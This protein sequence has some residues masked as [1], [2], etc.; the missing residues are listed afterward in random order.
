MHDLPHQLY[1]AADVR[2]LDRCAIE[3]FGISGEALMSR[4]GAAAFAVLRQCWP[5][6]ERIAVLCGTG[7]NGGDGFVLARLAHE[8]G[9]EVRVLRLGDT[10]LVRGDAATAA[11]AMIDA[12][13]STQA[14]GGGDLEGYDVIVD[15]MLGT[16]LERAVEGM[17]HE[18]IEEVNAA[19]SGVLALDI[20]SGLHADTGAIL[21]V[22]VEAAVTIAFI[23]LKQ[24]MFT[25]RGP[26]CCGV[27]RY[28]DLGVPA[29][30]FTRVPPSCLRLSYATVA[31]LLRLRR[32][33]AHKG[34]HGHVLVVGGDDGMAGAARLAGEAAARTGAG[35]V[36][37]ATRPAHAAALAAVRPELM[38]HGV[39]D[40]AALRPLLQRADVV[41]LGPGLG[42]RQWGQQ[43]LAEVLQTRLPLVVDADALNLLA[44]DPLH[45]D[46]W[47]L[48]PHPGEAGRLLGSDAA[49]V[50]ADRFAA[51]DAIRRRFGGFAI[52]KGAGTLLCDSDAD[53]ALCDGGNPGMACGGMGDVLTGVVA[54]LLAQRLEFADAA[55]LG[56]CLHAQAGDRAAAL[57]G[58]RGLLAGDL[59]IHLH[60]L[61]NP[62][63]H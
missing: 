39:P 7:N 60:H 35:L 23:G 47:V 3:E 11:R 30:V 50:Q 54:S 4:A 12:G 51:V 27:V 8:A 20:P 49:A 42:T 16:G 13:V 31:E 55:A 44:I 24:G 43:M 63:R 56:V 14:Y 5:K 40:G 59:M 10:G 62:V 9:I 36:S 6:A 53:L 18:A 19:D 46:N 26:D 38:A 61:A 28:H 17:W 52:L 21:G 32:R 2:R 58:E 33:T 1:R 15:A 45:R 34:D 48:T 41:A 29:Q 22:A 57:G 25:A 37:I